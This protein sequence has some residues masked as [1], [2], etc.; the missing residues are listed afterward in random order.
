MRAERRLADQPAHAVPL[1][2]LDDVHRALRTDQAAARHARADGDDNSVVALH[3]VCDRLR[4]HRVAR[5][6]GEIGM[7]DA[8]LFGAP[9]EGGDRMPFLQHPRHRKPADISGRAKNDDLH[10]GSPFMFRFT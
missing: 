8:D 7:F 4:V 10:G 5:V 2:R 9:R 3:G 1:H 6:Q